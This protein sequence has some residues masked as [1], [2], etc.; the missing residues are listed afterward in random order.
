MSY[1]LPILSFFSSMILAMVVIPKILVIAAKHSLFDIP[2]KR[3]KYRS[4]KYGGLSF[5]F[6][7]S[8]IFY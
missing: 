5:R 2:D 8:K 6:Q 1:I 4:E 7:Q 3:K